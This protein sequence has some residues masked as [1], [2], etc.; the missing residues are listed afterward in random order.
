MLAAAASDDQNLHRNRQHYVRALRHVN[1]CVQFLA[2]VPGGNQWFD[3]RRLSAPMP[4]SNNASGPLSLEEITRILLPYGGKAL[5]DSQ[6]AHFARYL[7]LLKR[8]NQTI[9]LTSIQDDTEIVARHF[10]E[11]IFADALLPMT[12]GRLAD[13]GSGAGFP[14]LPL[15]IAFPELQITLLEPNIK[16]CAFLREV[17][18]TLGL[19]GVEIVRNRYEDLHVPPGSFDFVCARALGGYKRLL[20]W[21]RTVL[22]P[23]GHVILW[24]GTEDSNVLTRVRGWHWALPAKIPESRQRVLLMGTPRP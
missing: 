19:F 13:V 20:L 1:A 21:A 5:T 9:P 16:K 24:L 17:Q 4:T 7:E 10:G 18:S 15:K 8:W 6:L 12:G 11:S 22:K 3:S 23:E 2:L 14:G